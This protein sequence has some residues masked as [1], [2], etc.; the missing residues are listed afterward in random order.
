MCSSDAFDIFGPLSIILSP[1]TVAVAL[2]AGEEEVSVFV[3]GLPTAP[4]YFR[5]QFALRFCWVYSLAKGNFPR[6]CC[7]EP[8]VESAPSDCAA[9][10]SR[11]LSVR[12]DALP[13]PSLA[14]ETTCDNEAALDRPATKEPSES[15]LSAL[16]LTLPLMGSL[17]RRS[18]LGLPILK[19]LSETASPLKVLDTEVSCG[20]G[21]LDGSPVN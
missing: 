8:M 10:T 13:S 3:L 2:L 14:V 16:A 12:C 15:R 11:L 17:Y 18:D 4:R 9:A 19:A 20:A 1:T 5:S 6:S 7:L 21:V